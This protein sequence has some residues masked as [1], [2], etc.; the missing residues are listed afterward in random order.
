VESKP[1][2]GLLGGLGVGAAVY[3]YEQLAKAH[4]DRGVPMHL[5]MAH[6]DMATGLRHVRAGEIAQLAEYFAELIGRLAA[7]GA[8]VAVI[9]AVTPHICIRELATRSPL[10]LISIADTTAAAVRARGLRRVAL[11][12]TRFTIESGFFGLLEGIEIARPRPE[13]IDFIHA[14][15]FEIVDAAAGGARQRDALTALANTICERDGVEAIVLAGTELALVFG[16]GAEFPAVDCA[17]LHLDAI[18]RE[19][20]VPL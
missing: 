17:R 3:Y 18:L 2:L 16:E 20:G 4:L 1:C 6:A 11:F 13:E 10:P 19:M 12:G 15:Y 7:A 14:M 8:T 5:I 9:P